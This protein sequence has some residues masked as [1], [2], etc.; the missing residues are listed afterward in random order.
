VHHDFANQELARLSYAEA[1][2]NSGRHVRVEAEVDERASRSRA[3][4]ARAR[5]ALAGLFAQAPAP[6]P[7]AR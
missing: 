1:L 7:S 2:R 5:D 6:S 4:L 3:L